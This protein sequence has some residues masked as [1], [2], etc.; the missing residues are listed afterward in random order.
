MYTD[1]I[2]TANWEASSGNRLTVPLGGD[3]GRVFKVGN[4]PINSRLEAY[5][6]VAGPE[7]DPDWQISFN[8]QFLFPK[9][10]NSGASVRNFEDLDGPHTLF[11]QNVTEGEYRDESTCALLQSKTC[12][13]SHGCW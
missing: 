3:F 12:N 6:N 1:N 4:L 7:G 13:E 9:S 10:R 8:W 2:I 5:Y 11:D